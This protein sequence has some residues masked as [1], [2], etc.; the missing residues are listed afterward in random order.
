MARWKRTG[1]QH[2]LAFIV[3]IFPFPLLP[4]VC[5]SYCG[6]FPQVVVIYNPLGWQRDEVVRIPVLCNYLPIEFKFEA[7]TSLGWYVRRLIYFL[8]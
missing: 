8:L 2:Y 7:F 5:S 6:F 3:Y 4:G 1:K